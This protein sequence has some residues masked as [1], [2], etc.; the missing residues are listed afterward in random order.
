MQI[1][2]ASGLI[3]GVRYVA[4]PNCDARPAGSPI[5]VLVIHSI[6][7]PPGRFGGSGIEQL[8]CNTL[9]PDEDLLS[10][11]RRQ[12]GTPVLERVRSGHLE[13]YS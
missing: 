1:D 9:N 3:Q 11:A 4:S 10:A 8:F 6:S 2:P 7:L 13:S 5:E 12:G